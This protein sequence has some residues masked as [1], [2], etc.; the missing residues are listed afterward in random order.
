MDTFTS[1]LTNA[2]AVVAPKKRKGKHTEHKRGFCFTGP[3]AAA[4]ATIFLSV[5]QICLACG[6]SEGRKLLA[7]PFHRRERGQGALQG[8]DM[9][10]VA[11][12]WC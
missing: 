4:A 10:A 11:K 8:K 7:S 1:N 3:T 12:D 6:G 2:A 9:I 5:V